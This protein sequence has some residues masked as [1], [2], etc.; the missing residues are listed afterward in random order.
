MQ[1]VG[2]GY[3]N[4]LP[5]WCFSLKLTSPRI[6]LY[7]VDS[8]ISVKTQELFLLVFL[9]RYLDLFTTFYSLY[10]SVMKIVYITIT[11]YIV[12]M[13]KHREPFKGL[14]NPDQDS[15]ALWKFAVAPCAFLAFVTH[16]VGSGISDFSFIELL[17]TFSIYLE[18]IAILPQLRVL[19]QY[20]L[21]ENLTAKFMFFLG[22]YR[23]F[24]ILNWIYRANTERNWRHHFVVYVCGVVQTLLYVDFFYQYFRICWGCCNGNKSRDDGDDEET[25]VLLFEQ[26]ISHR[27]ILDVS[28]DPLMTPDEET[29]RSGGEHLQIQTI[30]PMQS[31]EPRKRSRDDDEAQGTASVFE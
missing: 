3:S 13:I 21:V 12:F 23:A 20:R 2:G 6:R 17:W 14:Y 31:E 8:G 15:F 7:F 16:L 19:R 26:D 29:C 9:T 28:S 25:G 22:A 10:N 5:C 11:A 18:A 30:W 1:E 24:Y 4:S 27:K